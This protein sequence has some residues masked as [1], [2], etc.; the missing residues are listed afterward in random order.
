[1]DSRSIRR[2]AFLLDYRNRDSE[3]KHVVPEVAAKGYHAVA[4]AARIGE[5]DPFVEL[6][7]EAA[8]FRLEVIGFTQYMK[9]Q[10]TH[11]AYHPDQ[12][13]VRS[14]DKAALDQDQLPVST[15][16]P[17]N[18]AF[19]DRYLDFLARIARAPN[20]TDVLL[21]DESSLGADADRMGCYCHV[22]Q[23][24]WHEEFG[25]EIPRPPFKGREEKSRFVHWRWRRWNQ[26]HGRMKEALNRHHPVRAVFQSSPNSCL[27]GRNPWVTAVDLA[28][29]VEAIDGVMTDP[30]YTFHLAAS[31][32]PFVPREIYLSEHCRFLRGLAG[33]GKSAE[34]CP[35]GFSHPT[36]TRPLDE[37]DGWWTGVIPAALG[38]DAVAPYSY[39]LQR[40]SPVMET[41]EQSFRLDEYFARTR[42]VSFAAV[43]NSLE[44]QCFHIDGDTWARGEAFWLHSRMMP[45]GALLRHHCLPYTYL[46]SRRL[47]AETLREWPVVALPTVTCLS[48]E[49]RDHLR[50]YVRAGGILVTFGETATRDETGGLLSDEFT[51]ELFGVKDLTPGRQSLR[52]EPAREAATFAALAWPDEITAGYQDGASYPVLALRYTVL[53]EVDASAEILARFSGEPVPSAG[54]GFPA[55]T[56]KHVG[57][58]AGVFVAGT[59]S[60]EAVR[61]EFDGMLV[62]NFAGRVIGETIMELAGDRLPLRVS[63]RPPATAM[64]TVRPLDRRLVPATEFLPCVGEDLYLAAVVSYFREASRFQI[65]AD[66]NGRGCQRV[67]ELVADEEVRNLTQ[68]GDTAIVDVALTC[69]DAI[70]VFAFSLA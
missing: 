37:R 61:E 51:E 8:R 45:V 64:Q 10:T 67:R 65:E 4:F 15:G 49:A 44:T 21:N 68:E 55:M 30:Y 29:M 58:G 41:Y 32:G 20:M 66:L 6:A 34:V 62:L 60:H 70:R 24:A 42:P 33:P 9:S 36:F 35:P 12:R 26:V 38:M 43:V 1:M 46:P 57:R 28:S 39:L 69:D 14:S 7:D 40:I 59:P 5:E 16:C 23:K 3:L 54:A 25:G 27:L 31:A 11:L 63:P 13:M 22:C 17:F 2:V 47:V 50:D 52:F 18:P 19:L 56:I 53:A 48:A